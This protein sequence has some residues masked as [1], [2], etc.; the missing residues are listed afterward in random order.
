MTKQKNKWEKIIGC[1]GEFKNDGIFYII[2][3]AKAQR[4]D[5]AGERLTYMV[6]KVDRSSVYFTSNGLM[7]AYTF[8]KYCKII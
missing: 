4:L 8:K 3:N 2:S 5:N 1:I 6:V 7:V